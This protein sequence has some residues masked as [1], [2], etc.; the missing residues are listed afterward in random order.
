[1]MQSTICVHSNRR[2]KIELRMMMTQRGKQLSA[3]GFQMCLQ[4]RKHHLLDQLANIS[5]DQAVNNHQ[6]QATNLQEKP[7]HLKK[8][9]RWRN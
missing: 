7:E 3:L 8:K 9:S 2:S 4:E 1:M 5:Q 6:T